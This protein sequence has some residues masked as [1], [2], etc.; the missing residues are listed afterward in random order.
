MRIYL[1]ALPTA[2]YFVAATAFPS[3]T[4][5]T[6]WH[7]AAV[8]TLS[9]LL[10]GGF[11]FA[12]YGN[13]RMDYITHREVQAIQHLYAIAPPGSVIVGLSSYMPSQDRAIEQYDVES[14]FTLDLQPSWAQRPLLERGDV[15]F[16]V[17][18]MQSYCPRRSYF[19]LTREQMAAVELLS[20]GPH[21][22]MVRLHEQFLATARLRLIFNN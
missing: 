4:Q 18:K 9:A 16:I 12:R 15:Q 17:Q 2:A 13:E 22:Q 10:L 5:R 20:G 1:F 11:L 6:S 21:P 14:E 19:I 8:G 7:A 3:S